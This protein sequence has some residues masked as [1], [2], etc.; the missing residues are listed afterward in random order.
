MPGERV[1]N[2]LTWMRSYL[3]SSVRQVAPQETEITSYR[4]GELNVSVE[5]DDLNLDI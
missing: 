2:P 3:D 4:V 5:L 1:K